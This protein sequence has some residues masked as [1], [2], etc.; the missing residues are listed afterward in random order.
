M[1]KPR[2]ATP[3]QKPKKT[4]LTIEIE[5][6]VNLLNINHFTGHKGGQIVKDTSA[7]YYK[8]GY[9]DFKSGNKL[10]GRI[11]YDKQFSC[12]SRIVADLDFHKLN[13]YAKICVPVPKNNEQRKELLAALYDM[14]FASDD[15]SFREYSKDV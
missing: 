15:F 2:K 7:T 11:F 10:Q 8:N 12:D 1:K 14:Q 4:R 13:K 9:W 6:I 5:A 3:K